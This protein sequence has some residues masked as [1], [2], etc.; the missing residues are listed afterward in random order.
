MEPDAYPGKP[1]KN[2]EKKNICIF[3]LM[4]RG[5]F[6]LL[7]FKTSAN[8][9]YY[10]IPKLKDGTHISFHPKKI[11]L[12]H[13]EKYSDVD[14]GSFFASSILFI[15]FRSPCFCI[16]IGEKISKKDIELVFPILAKFL[17][18]NQKE[19]S[20][21]IDKLNNQRFLKFSHPKLK[22]PF[23]IKSIIWFKRKIK[24]FKF[25]EK[26]DDF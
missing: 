23:F 17:P 6:E 2:I 4:N 15:K 22:I 3:Q 5:C 9:V 19:N 25:Q 24:N 14:I 1:P 8:S 12:K 13:N 11:H 20:K 7:R 10:M 21:F 16:R 18:I 26:F